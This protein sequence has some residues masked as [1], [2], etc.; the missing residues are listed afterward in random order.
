M[1]ENIDVTINSVQLSF[2]LP[3]TNKV[4]AKGWLGKSVLPPP[5][6]TPDF[7]LT[8]TG[9]QGPEQ[10]PTTEANC[11][12]IQFRVNDETEWRTGQIDANTLA[13]GVPYILTSGKMQ[14]ASGTVQEGAVSFG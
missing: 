11:A 6:G 12:T 2:V 1:S 10:I 5:D 14:P 3:D 4:E 9:D 7:H 8:Y 13:L